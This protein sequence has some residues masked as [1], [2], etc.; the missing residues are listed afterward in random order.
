M[1]E[2]NIGKCLKIVESHNNKVSKT[3][4][5]NNANTA[6]DKKPIEERSISLSEVVSAQLLAINNTEG[7]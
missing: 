3:N 6:T 2:I 5:I 1:S 7:K 4:T